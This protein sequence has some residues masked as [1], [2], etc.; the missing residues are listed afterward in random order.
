MCTYSG[1]SVKLDTMLRNEMLHIA[2]QTY[3][4]AYVHVE[5]GD[6]LSL[7]PL[8][9][10]VSLCLFISFA[11]QPSSQAF[12]S[13]FSLFVASTQSFSHYACILWEYLNTSFHNFYMSM[14]RIKWRIKIS[15][16]K[17]FCIIRIIMQLFKYWIF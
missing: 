11:S 16:N 14:L 5:I 4:C 13:S 10:L 2:G 8:P 12:S 15:K 3:V 9:E 1:G 7:I 17:E 6:S